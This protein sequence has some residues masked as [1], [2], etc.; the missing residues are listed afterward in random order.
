VRGTAYSS[1]INAVGHLIEQHGHQSAEYTYRNEAGESVGI[2]LRWDTSTGKRIRP[3]SRFDNCWRTAGMPVPRPLYRL[4]ELLATQPS[5]GTQSSSG[6]RGDTVFVVEGE[7]CADALAELDLLAT[8]SA[9]GSNSAAK[10]DWSQLAGRRVVMVPDNDAAGGKYAAAVAQ[11][12]GQLSPPAEVCVLLLPGLPAGGDVYDWID[13]QGATPRKEVASQLLQLARDCTPLPGPSENPLSDNPAAPAA[14]DDRSS[15]G[16]AGSAGEAAD[17]A[18]SYA[19][20]PFPVEALPP[21]LR[22]Y[23]S[24]ASQA[25]GCE[26]A[27]VAL[28]LLAVV[29]SAIGNARRLELKRGWTEPAILWTAIIGDSGSQKSA[30]LDY[31]IDTFGA[32]QK[33]M[34][35]DYELQLVEHRD[36]LLV[37]GQELARWKRQGDSS[38]PPAEPEP[39]VAPRLWT[40]DPTVQAL[41]TL[42][43]KHPR[44]M[45][46]KRDELAGWL[47]S[48]DRFSSGPGGDVAQWLEMFGGRAM[49]IDRKS[50]DDRLLNI[51]HASVNITGGIQPST[52]RRSL[53]K[54]YFENGLAARLL[55]A[56]PPQQTRQWSEAEVSPATEARLVE[57]FGRLEQLQ[58]D[59]GDDANGPRIVK[60]DPAAKQKWVAFYNRHALQHEML[61]EELS[62]A[63][64]KLEGYTARLALVLHLAEWAGEAPLNEAQWNEANGNKANESGAN[65]NDANGSGPAEA[66]TPAAN[67][68][69]H[70]S[71]EAIE[72]GVQLCEWFGY[73][74]ERVYAILQASEADE[75]LRKLAEW[76]ARRGGSTTARMVAKVL[77]AYTSESAELALSRLVSAGYGRWQEVR[78]TA[79]GGRPTRKFELFPPQAKTL[80]KA[81]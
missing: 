64:S 25:I 19:Y 3:V 74:T 27:F 28:P 34:M 18:G 56:Y 24:E 73:E 40:D 12:L 79:S 44:G 58:M 62:A 78:P 43:A 48:F 57:M 68:P 69:P 71:A 2:V 10:T 80:P 63:W 23:V 50:T 53:S 37:Y 32:R 75:Q 38:N 77:S 1:A 36:N 67:D 49:M 41:T 16:S 26:A 9:H 20:R 72:R 35:A 39:P 47:A 15:A 45:L 31:A 8:T 4:P 70:L 33:K 59:G 13:Q 14:A 55:L 52:L 30:A 81:G 6:N 42:L 17:S 66:T 29:A 21:V 7:K 60:L 61:S 22:A 65:G 51:P 11:Q 46:V 5:S 54:Q 76:V